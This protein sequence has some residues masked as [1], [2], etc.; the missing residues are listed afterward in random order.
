MTA[1]KPKSVGSI[2]KKRAR[3]RRAQQKLRAERLNRTH[4]LEQQCKVYEKEIQELRAEN[5]A[6]RSAQQRIREIVCTSE[7][8]NHETLANR[9]GREPKS[10]EVCPAISHACL[11]HAAHYPTVSGH[12]S[13]FFRYPLN[14]SVP[15]IETIVQS[16]NGTSLSP[17]KFT[18]LN[19]ARDLDLSLWSRLPLHLAQEPYNPES[20]YSCFNRPDLVQASPD[21]PSPVE[22]LYGSSQNFLADRI[23]K[24][25]RFWPICD[26]ERLASGL[27]T[28]NMVKWLTRPSQGSFA[29]LLEFQR[30]VNDQLQSPHPRCIDFVMWP[31]LRANL[32]KTFHLYDLKMVFAA[33]TCSLRIRW[34]WGKSFLEPDTANSLQVHKEFY[35]TFTRIEGWGLS[36]EFRTQYPELMVG[37]DIET[38]SIIPSLAAS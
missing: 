7:L 3:D 21:E 32:V 13:G 14:D 11:H 36:D 29:R 18:G 10:V 1:S 9:D 27:L 12:P 15:P 34:P 26:P 17:A 33:F 8:N 31:A 2:D 5:E 24:A 35:D 25:I 23:H 16:S 37:I 30:P 20:L 19:V 38:L 22:I 4:S 28:Y 6:L